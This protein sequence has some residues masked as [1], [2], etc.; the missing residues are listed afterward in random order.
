MHNETWNCPEDGDYMEL[1]I[2]DNGVT[3]GIGQKFDFERPTYEE[4]AKQLEN[5]GY[6]KL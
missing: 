3:Y 1:T 5:W 4:A 6:H 2:E